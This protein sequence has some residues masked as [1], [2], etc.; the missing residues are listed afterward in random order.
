MSENQ[1]SQIVTLR[2]ALDWLKRD[3]V[4]RGAIRINDK[5]SLLVFLH[6]PLNY[7]MCLL[8]LKEWSVNAKV[9]F[10]FRWPIAYLFRRQSIKLGF[11]IPPNTFGSGLA[12]VHYGNIVVNGNAR[13]GENC[14]IHVGVNIGGAGG[15]VD[16]ESAK[17]LSP[18]LG[19][20]IY[21]A[22]GAK[23]Y[24]PVRIADNIAIGANAVVNRS[25]TTPGVTI[26]GMPAKKIS[27]KGSTGMIFD[28]A[29][30]NK[31]II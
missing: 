18:S 14:R 28:V 26:A 25:F 4:Q 24:G 13:I 22:P 12:I 27:E 3:L 6:D 20:N 29:Q 2:Q 15:L 17:S 21:I 19:C 23:I 31:P 10:L 7:F 9:S 8:R 16:N 5:I 11:S 30:S 1:F